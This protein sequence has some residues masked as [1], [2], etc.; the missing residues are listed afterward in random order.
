MDEAKRLIAFRCEHSAAKQLEALAREGDR[1]LSAEIRRAV[2]EHVASCALAS[3]GEV[4]RV[5]EVERR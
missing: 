1:S 2:R 5:A 3:R 4:E